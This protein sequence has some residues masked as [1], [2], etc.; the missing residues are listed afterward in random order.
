AIMCCSTN[1]S[2][3]TAGVVSARHIRPVGRGW[4][5]SSSSRAVANRCETATPGVAVWRHVEMPPL[6][7]L[8]TATPGVAVSESAVTPPTNPPRAPAPEHI[9]QPVMPA[10]PVQRVLEGQKALV[11]G[12]SSGIGRAIALAL[13][14]AGA[15]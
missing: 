1:T 4:S 13:G 5:R 15:D 2:T 10:C 6:D 12:A 9:P 7:H 8:Q 14:D 3:A 11:T